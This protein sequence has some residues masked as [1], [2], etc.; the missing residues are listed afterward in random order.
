MSF[1]R[2]FGLLCIVFG[3]FVILFALHELIL[4]M[5]IALLGLFL[6]NF[7]LKLRGMPTLYIT[8]IR[9]WSSRYDF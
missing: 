1:D 8:L 5:L 2:V 6:I 4:R 3:L 9:M 7:G